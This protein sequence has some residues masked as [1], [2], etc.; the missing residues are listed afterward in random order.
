[1][2]GFDRKFKPKYKV[3][4][5]LD[6]VLKTLEFPNLL[7]AACKRQPRTLHLMANTSNV[8]TSSGLEDMDVCLAFSDSGSQTLS[9][10]EAFANTLLKITSELRKRG[11]TDKELP[12]SPKA[13]LMK[14]KILDTS[15]PD[16]T[17]RGR[18]LHKYLKSKIVPANQADEITPPPEN[19]NI[20]DN[21]VSHLKEGYLILQKISAKTLHLSLI[22]GVWLNIAFQVYEIYKATGLLK[23]P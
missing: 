19:I 4:A 6:G 16:K 2:T 8:S 13:D 10:Y 9:Q 21:I 12:P 11:F 18:E 20:M 3:D 15:K 1:M 5:P 17:L 23:E 14:M 7:I 22:Y